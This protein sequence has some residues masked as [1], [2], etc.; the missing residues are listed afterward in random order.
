VHSSSP[1]QPPGCGLAGKA[2]RCCT[3]KH[4]HTSVMNDE[5]RPHQ[6][7]DSRDSYRGREKG[8]PF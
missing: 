6:S 5:V 3:A 7:R 2:R 4:I 8:A 1:C